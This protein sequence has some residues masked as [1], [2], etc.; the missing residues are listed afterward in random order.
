MC[1]ISQKYR[2]IKQFFINPVLKFLVKYNIKILTIYFL[3]LTYAI[4]ILIHYLIHLECLSVINLLF[5]NICLH[6]FF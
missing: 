2:N 6:H 3:I 1:I 4:I 5:R